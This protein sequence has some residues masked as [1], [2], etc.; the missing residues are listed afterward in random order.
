VRGQFASATLRGPVKTFRV[1]LDPGAIPRGPASPLRR[2]SLLHVADYRSTW[3]Q[4]LHEKCYFFSSAA[5]LVTSIRGGSF[6]SAI[7]LTKNW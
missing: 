3:T 1:R 2:R 6:S 4:G 5:Q 7:V